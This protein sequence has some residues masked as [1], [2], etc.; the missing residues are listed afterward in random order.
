MIHQHSHISNPDLLC[1][2]HI[3]RPQIL[4]PF[5]GQRMYDTLV[6]Y[7][8]TSDKAGHAVYYKQTE[9]GVTFSEDHMT[10]RVGRDL[11]RLSK[12][13]YLEH[14]PQYALYLRDDRHIMKAR[15]GG[16]EFEETLEETGVS[17]S[18]TATS[19]RKTFEAP[20]I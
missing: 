9:A 11:V 18:L 7:I 17:I 1:V 5:F 19:G 4:L 12:P 6:P 16:D 13:I 8:Q 15:G 3:K 2:T 10:A 14:D 20:V